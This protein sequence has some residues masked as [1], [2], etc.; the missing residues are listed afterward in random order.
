LALIERWASVPW[1]L[2]DAD[3][4]K[5]VFINLMGN[6]VDAMPDG[7]TLTVRTELRERAGS[8]AV[9]IIDSGVGMTS[10][11]LTR[12]FEPFYTTKPVGKG[13]GLGLSVS[14]GIVKNHN[15]TLEARSEP[16]KGTTMIVSLPLPAPKERAPRRPLER[17]R[18]A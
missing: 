2:G 4:L 1:I 9:N 3:Q 15:G 10:E 6:A 5:Q 14:L 17:S 7:G 18:V 16:G 13:T 8:V 12:I 11:Q